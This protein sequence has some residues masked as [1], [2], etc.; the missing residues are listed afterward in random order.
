VATRIDGG[1]QAI[2]DDEVRFPTCS[3]QRYASYEGDGAL[4]EMVPYREQPGEATAVRVDGLWLLLQLD[5]FEG[6]AACHAPEGTED[7]S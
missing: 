4:V 2:S 6:Q 5:S 1:I 7:P 3:E